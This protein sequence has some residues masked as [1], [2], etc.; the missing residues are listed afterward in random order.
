MTDDAVHVRKR[1]PGAAVEVVEARVD[2]DEPEWAAGSD[3]RAY[4]LA[5][6]FDDVGLAP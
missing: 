6:D 1:G 5:G 4:E 2:S 3:G